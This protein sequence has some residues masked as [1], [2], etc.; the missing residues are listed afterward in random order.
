MDTLTYDLSVKFKEY[1]QK[2]TLES[3]L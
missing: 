2:Q 3:Y 1:M